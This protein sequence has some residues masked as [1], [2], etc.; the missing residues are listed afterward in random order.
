MAKA[1]SSAG[2]DR[3]AGFRPSDEAA[4]HTIEHELAETLFVEASA[5]TGKTHSLVARMVNLVAEG[6]TTLDRVAAI[7]FTEAAASELR[8]RIREGLEREAETV[9]DEARRE[10]C[11]R[12]IAD[13]D[14]ATIRTL[15]S[16]AGMLLHERPLEAG[17]PPGFE[18]TDGI[19]AGLRFDDAWEA[20][21][22]EM[23]ETGS[24]LAPHLSV[25]LSLGL[26]LQ[27]LKQVARAF[28]DNYDDLRGADFEAGPPLQGNAARAV[29]A[30]WPA[31]E[32]LCGFS[33]LGSEDALFNHIQVQAGNAEPIVGGRS[34]FG[35]LLPAAVQA[36][37]TEDQYGQ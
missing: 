15:H 1:P 13:L 24:A 34:R 6:A 25:A 12:G 14:Q 7:T 36:P 10:R 31:V 4:R 18:I 26:S 35:Q 3:N 19:A 20:W 29:L 23:L 27:R 8:Y 30:Q 32:R 37:A 21:L 16:F 11:T 17:L 28:H 5:G 9:Q 2:S 22:D 33:R